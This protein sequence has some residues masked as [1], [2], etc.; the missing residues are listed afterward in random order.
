MEYFGEER[1]P[2]GLSLD[3]RSVWQCCVCFIDNSISEKSIV[4]ECYAK[5]IFILHGDKKSNL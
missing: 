4:T 2:A 5:P 3:P 1:T